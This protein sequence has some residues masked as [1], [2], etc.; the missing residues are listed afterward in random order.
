MLFQIKVVSLIYQKQKDMTLSKTNKKIIF[1]MNAMVRSLAMVN[2]VTKSIL[3]SYLH[4]LPIDED[5]S[6][7][8]SYVVK[9]FDDSTRLV[10]DFI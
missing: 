9:E 6:D 1:V 7:T 8:F 3:N 5:L 2:M 10:I 4:D